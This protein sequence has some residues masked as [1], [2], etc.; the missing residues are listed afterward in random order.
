[1]NLPLSSSHRYLAETAEAQKLA[2]EDPDFESLLYHEKLNKALQQAFRADISGESG[3]DLI[4]VHDFSASA[5]L[6][7]ERGDS[8]EFYG[9]EQVDI[10]GVGIFAPGLW[11][12][13]RILYVFDSEKRRK[14]SEIALVYL[15]KAHEEACRRWPEIAD[16]KRLAL[17]AD[18]ARYYRSKEFIYGLRFSPKCK[19][20]TQI[21]RPR[22]D[23]VQKVGHEDTVRF[24]GWVDGGGVWGG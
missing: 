13:I 3:F 18:C 20:T 24:G 15:R 17:W 11:E 5:K 10:F 23:A 8:V 9:G 22:W 4:L 6:E 21:F 16:T 19:T 12:G 14:T 1:M 7:H 2:V